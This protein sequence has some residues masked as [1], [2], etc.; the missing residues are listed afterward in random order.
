MSDDDVRIISPSSASSIAILINET[1]LSSASPTLISPSGTVPSTASSISILSPSSS[2]S[3][4]EPSSYTSERIYHLLKY[5]KHQ[6]D[7]ID[8]KAPIAT[9]SHWS[10]F[11][12][13]AKFNKETN[14]FERIMGFTSCRICKKTLV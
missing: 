1:I 14:D 13:Q 8:N 3:S 10:V 5:E 7:V 11:G 6:Y 2:S 4:S 12:F 9:G